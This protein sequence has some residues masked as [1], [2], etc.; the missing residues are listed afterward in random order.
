MRRFPDLPWYTNTS[1]R[2]RRRRGCPFCRQPCRR[3]RPAARRRIDSGGATISNLSLPNSRCARN[4]SFSHASS[5]SPTPRSTKVT[6][7]PR[8]P[9][10]STGTFLKSSPTNSFALSAEPNFFSR[11]APRRQ[12]IPARAARG[13]RVR[14]DHLH[15]RLDQIVPVLDALGIALAHQE[16]DR[17]GVG[18]RIERQALLPVRRDQALGGDGVDVIGQRQRDDIG[19]QAVDHRRAPASRSRHA[20]A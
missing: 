20:T 16:H 4:A 5:T 7:E 17:R 1:D 8:A 2:P 14:R 6:V 13:L 15:A 19:L 9:V 18:R 11:V 3:S 10:S 12:I